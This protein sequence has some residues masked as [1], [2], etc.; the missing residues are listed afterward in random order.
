[1]AG[2]FLNGMDKLNR[3]ISITI[4]PGTIVKTILIL[5]FFYFLFA[6][7]DLILVVLTAIV[8]ASSIE[9]ITLWFGKYKI[10]RL[11]A[12]IIIY[13]GLALLFIGIIY[14]FLP[15]LLGD[16]ST[17]LAN[18]PQYLD[19]VHVWLPISESTLADTSERF[20]QLSTDFSIKDLIGNIQG[21]LANVS[22]GF[23]HSV[24]FIFGGVLSFV[25]IVVL[26]FYLA[27]QES[28]IEDFLRIITPNRHEAYVIGLWKRSQKKIGLYMQGQLLLA[29]IVG[30]L[31]FLGLSILNIKQALLLAF[32][33]A[34]FEVIPIF[35]PIL[36]AIPAI[37]IGAAQG[38]LT[39]AVIVAGLYIII[40]QFENHLIYPLVVKKIVGVSPIVVI[41]ALI[42]GAK[43]A[44]FLGVVLSVPVSAA[45]MEYLH[46][47]QRE[48]VADE[49]VTIT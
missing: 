34:A 4:T 22:E 40:Q 46:D 21:A 7:R 16:L 1:M 20:R 28:G 41:L 13:V 48:K 36:S 10:R 39:T 11:P 14:V 26:S 9:P 47:I 35:G 45:I 18:F 8:F 44:G 23:V 29:L 24:S 43:L 19:Y 32:L 25:I 5:I 31:V 30:I 38:G 6:V 37:L 27:V 33:A 42:V 49:H 17:Y 2:G 12:V 3:P 15:T